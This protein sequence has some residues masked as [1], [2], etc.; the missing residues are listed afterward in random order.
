V[1]KFVVGADYSQNSVV[2]GQQTTFEVCGFIHCLNLI[3]WESMVSED[4]AIDW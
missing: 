3:N 1:I 4:N 2:I